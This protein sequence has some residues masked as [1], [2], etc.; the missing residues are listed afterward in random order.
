MGTPVCQGSGV[1]ECVREQFCAVID[2]YP[3]KTR[4]QATL[5]GSCGGNARESFDRRPEGAPVTAGTETN[6]PLVEP[7]GNLVQ[8]LGAEVRRQGN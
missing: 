3:Q 4:L 7:Q 8:V 2:G 6:L 1:V 5:R